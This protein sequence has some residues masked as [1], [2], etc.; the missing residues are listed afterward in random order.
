MNPMTISVL[1]LVIAFILA[2]VILWL[3][4]MKFVLKDPHA[5]KKE[6]SWD[7][8]LAYSG[9]FAVIIAIIVLLVTEVMNKN[10]GVKTGM[11]PSYRYCGAMH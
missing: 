8:L 5:D 3:S 11:S 4:K 7:K 2:L 10:K 6:I 9:L 1:A